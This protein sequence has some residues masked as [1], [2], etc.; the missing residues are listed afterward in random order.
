[1]PENRAG[2]SGKGEQAVTRSR[3]LSLDLLENR[4]SAEEG[5]E[6]G[7]E[8]GNDESRSRLT[9]TLRKAVDGE[10][11]PRQRECVLLYYGGGRN[12]K[13]VASELGISVP[14]V[15]RHLRKARERLRRILNYSLP[16]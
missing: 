16:G 6:A 15:S 3:Y 11:T 12:E 10:L 1:M 7:E 9:R 5:A 13:E 14:A 2:A 8:A 4:V